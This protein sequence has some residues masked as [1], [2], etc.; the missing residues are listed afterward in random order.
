MAVTVIAEDG[1]IEW[2]WGVRVIR[3]DTLLS[4]KM[5]SMSSFEKD[6]S[7]EACRI[8]CVKVV[9]VGSYG[10]SGHVGHEATRDPCIEA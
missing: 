10:R 1:F 4:A 5:R 2:R 9:F 6:L 3:K 8:L 7:L